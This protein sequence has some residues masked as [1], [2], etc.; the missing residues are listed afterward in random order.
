MNKATQRSVQKL[1]EEVLVQMGCLRLDLSHRQVKRSC[2]ALVAAKILSL[3][4]LQ[5]FTQ[6][7]EGSAGLL[8]NQHYK[9]IVEHGVQPAVAH[10]EPLMAALLADKKVD[11]AALQAAVASLEAALGSR[12]HIEAPF[13]QTGQLHAASLVV[14]KIQS[15]ENIE[16]FMAGDK[17]DML[18]RR[19]MDCWRKCNEHST[20]HSGATIDA[21]APLRTDVW[22]V[23][24]ELVKA[25]QS[26]VDRMIAD[27]V[28]VRPCQ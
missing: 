13:L 25:R 19:L 9:D 6:S 17:D 1:H 21:L 8:E 23:L 11:A 2:D 3:E 12:M 14:H 28:E 16:S 10:I 7:I 18:A 22:N 20:K 26:N 5:D 27:N 4:V 15:F 24:S